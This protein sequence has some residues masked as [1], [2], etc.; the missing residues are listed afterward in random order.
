VHRAVHVER[1]VCRADDPP[2]LA[3]CHLEVAPFHLHLRPFDRHHP[4]LRLCRQTLRDPCGIGFQALLDLAL[5]LR[6]RF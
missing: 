4:R 3:H 6:G 5:H 1:G 2:V